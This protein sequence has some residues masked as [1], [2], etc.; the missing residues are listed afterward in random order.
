M[1]VPKGL[2]TKIMEVAAILVGRQRCSTKL[3]K[4]VNQ[5]PLHQIL[6]AI[7][8]VMKIPSEYK[9]LSWA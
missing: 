8:T 2:V 5:G 6:V 7:S 9:F 4:M 3:L 1:N